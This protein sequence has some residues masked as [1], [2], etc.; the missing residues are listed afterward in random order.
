MSSVIRDRRLGIVW[1]AARLWVGYEFF[2]AGWQKSTSES[3]SWWG[4]T[5]GVHGF[6]SNAGSSAS[7]SGAHAAVPHWYASVVNHV[8]LHLDHVFAIAI[9]LG[10]LLV[11]AGLIL[12]LFTMA[13]AFFG[14][15]LNLNFMLSGSTG[16]GLN[17]EMLTLGMLILFAGSAA[18]VF[19]VDRFLLPRLKT[20]LSDRR[21]KTVAPRPVPIA[22]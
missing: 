4:S 14:V 6:L 3:S 2:H 9:P 18:Y 10:E 17:P 22:H 1:L 19:G 11:G 21:R 16:A 12:G 20:G 5:S 15:L 13:S 7:T 8:F